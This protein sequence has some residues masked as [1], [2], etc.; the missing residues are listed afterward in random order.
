MIRPATSSDVDAIFVYLLIAH[1]R[2][3]DHA[4]SVDEEKTREVLAYLIEHAFCWISV[5]GRVTGILA[6]MIDE[7]WY[8]REKLAT[9]LLFTASEDGAALLKRFLRW[10]E[11]QKVAEVIM[12]ITSDAAPKRVSQLY[13]QVGLPRVGGLHAKVFGG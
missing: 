13:E 2:E 10:A 7:L 9:D 8:S 3:A 12:A 4:I 5:N 6:G 11:E 1:A